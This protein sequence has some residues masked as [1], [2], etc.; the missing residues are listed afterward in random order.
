MKRASFLGAMV[1][2]L[3]CLLYWIF[4][5]GLLLGLLISLVVTGGFTVFFIVHR[6]RWVRD[7]LFSACCFAVSTLILFVP[8]T[9]YYNTVETFDGATCTITVR[10]TR[11]P[12]LTS[13]GSYRYTAKPIGKIF[14]Q[15][16]VFFSPVY[17]TDGGGTV[18]AKFTFSRPDDAYFLE[19]LSEGVAL[20]AVIRNP[21]EVRS[22]ESGPSFYTVSSTLRRYVST[23]FLRYIGGSEAGFMTSVLT[24]E[25]ESLSSGDYELLRQTGMLHIVAVSGFHVSVFITFLLFFLQ[26]IRSLRVQIILSVLSLGV[27]FL[28][29]GFTPSVCRAVIMN[30]I[31]F[32]SHWVA[33]RTEPFNRL[34]LA[35]IVILLIS[36]YAVWSLSFQ[37]S[38]S[39]ALG[40]LLFS[41]PFTKALLHWL[42]VRCHVICGSVLR[43]L[44]TLFCVSVSA[45]ILTL[46][47]L[48]IRMNSYSVWSLFLSPVMLPVLQICF[49]GALV[50]L[51]LALLSFFTP[52]CKIIGFLIGYGVK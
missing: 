35:A 50:L 16:I 37:L 38:F 28:L 33:V 51:L 19:N 27:I 41:E 31:V 34:G 5:K 2:C 44:I 36:P 26:K 45:F 7:L 25:K 20:T 42:F 17:Y 32:G 9:D 1:L 24:G 14:S 47:L 43:N 11:D 49:F 6:K 3:A 23:T 12:E 29:S 4:P 13:S 52:F 48:W 46:P 15:K 10:L 8:V 40:I 22:E 39:A 21:H 30:L 18:K